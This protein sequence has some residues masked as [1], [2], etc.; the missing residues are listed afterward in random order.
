MP[1]VDRF[2]ITMPPELGSAVRDAAERDGVSM[3]AWLSEAAA[4]RL[5]NDALGVALAA[6]ERE[7]GA[8]TEEELAAA[9]ES[10]GLRWHPE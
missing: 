8:F 4:D 10:M 3:S 1:Q 9:A 6:W 5:R 2:S 7:H